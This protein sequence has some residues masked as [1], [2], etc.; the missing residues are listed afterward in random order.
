M[1]RVNLN[2]LELLY[3]IARQ[4]IGLSAIM[5]VTYVEELARHKEIRLQ[6]LKCKE[7]AIRC[8]SELN[9]T[10][11]S[12][13]I[14]MGELYMRSVLRCLMPEGDEDAVWAA[15]KQESGGMEPERPRRE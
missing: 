3:P 12:G 6:D 11:A 13:R 1:H 10:I 9:L 5:S 2:A 15:L 8:G 7:D 14:A 4:T